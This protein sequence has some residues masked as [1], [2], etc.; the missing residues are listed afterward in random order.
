MANMAAAAATVAIAGV[1]DVAAAV[2]CT[3]MAANIIDTCI[4]SI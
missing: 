1:A 3:V 4:P 2:E